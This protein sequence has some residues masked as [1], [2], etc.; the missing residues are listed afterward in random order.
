MESFLKEYEYYIT[1]E[2]N[3][4]LNTYQSYQ[5]DISQYL[6]Y[7]Q[8]YRNRLDPEDIT[9]EDIRSYLGSL[10]RHHISPTSQARKLSAI[11]SFHKFLFIEKYT[12]KNVSKQISSPKQEKKLPIILSIAEVDLLLNSL[13]TNNQFELRNKAMIELVYSSG[14]RVSELINLRLSNLHLQM[15]FIEVY[16]K[17]KKE[18]IVPINDQAINILNLYLQDG[19]PKLIHKHHN[20]YLFL[21][22][23]GEGLTRQSFFLILKEKAKAAG[24]KKPISPHKL[25]HSFASH[26]L[27]R[28]IDLRFI[29]E[30]LGHEDISTTEIY[31]HIN[32]VRLKEIYLDAHPRAQKGVK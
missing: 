3:L 11:R 2:Q 13:N 23:H 27:E 20:D 18:R 24:I 22:H 10:N 25:R 16:G 19:R 17:G 9:I 12:T 28:G 5:K 31:T 32:N 29:Q 14:L 26:L 30:L 1:G 8:K 6:E 7:L 21:N 15:G 4:S